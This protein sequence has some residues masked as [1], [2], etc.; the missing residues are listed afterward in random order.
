MFLSHFQ[1]D[2]HFISLNLKIW[3]L[4]IFKAAL[5]SQMQLSCPYK[6]LS[7]QTLKHLQFLRNISDTKIQIFNFREVKCSSVWRYDKNISIFWQKRTFTKFF[8]FASALVNKSY[9]SGLKTLCSDGWTFEMKNWVSDDYVV[10]CKT[11]IFF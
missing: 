6:P 5:A 1:T 4:V 10:L 11:N 9:W 2:E 7:F 8:Y 3:I